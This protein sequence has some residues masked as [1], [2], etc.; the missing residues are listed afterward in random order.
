M[1]E[2]RNHLLSTIVGLFGEQMKYRMLM[3]KELFLI[4]ATETWD[5][6]ESGKKGYNISFWWL[7]SFFLVFPLVHLVFLFS[8]SQLDFIF[9]EEY[10]QMQTVRVAIFYD[11]Y[12]YYWRSTHVYCNLVCGW[13]GHIFSNICGYVLRYSSFSSQCAIIICVCLCLLIALD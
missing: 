4:L 1:S 13:S 10:M 6:N 7:S 8:L 11:Y 2:D 9:V 12:C 5:S 3:S